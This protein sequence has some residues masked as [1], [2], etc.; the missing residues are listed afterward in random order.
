LG[1]A[2]RALRTAC[3]QTP[4]GVSTGLWIAPDPQRRHALV[5]RWDDLPDFAGVNFSEP[6]APDLCELLLGRGVA[7]EAGLWTADDTRLLIAR[8]LA[9]RCLRRLIEPQD[10]VVDA[11]LETVGAIERLLDASAVP[12]P[13]L[14][15]GSG[16]TV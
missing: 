7:V 2:L 3:P 13:R 11:A 8:G 5:A 9:S 12:T 1:A 16:A 10:A 14:L 4:L 15:H 6:G